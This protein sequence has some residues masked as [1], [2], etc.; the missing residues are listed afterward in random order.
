VDFR[1]KVM[2]VAVGVV[3][4]LLMYRRW[5]KQVN[6]FLATTVRRIWGFL[7]DSKTCKV[8]ETFCNEVAVLWF[9]FPLLDL[10]YDG[11]NKSI[12]SLLPQAFTT[13]FAFLVF[14]IILSHV[15]ESEEK[16]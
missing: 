5:H 16:D 1:L 4:S 13:A 3:V 15:A 11:Q 8:A 7:T 10:L 9:V 2:I 12:G 14:A 6:H